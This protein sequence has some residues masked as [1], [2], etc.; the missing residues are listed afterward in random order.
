M[1]SYTSETNPDIV[2]TLESEKSVS[3][4]GNP[5]FVGFTN[6]FGDCKPRFL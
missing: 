3:G 4:Y 6:H 5:N 2:R 1:G